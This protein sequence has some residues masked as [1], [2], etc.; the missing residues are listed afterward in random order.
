[1]TNNPFTYLTLF[2]CVMFAIVIIVSYF[3]YHN[4]LWFVIEQLKIA[5]FCIGFYVVLS[6]WAN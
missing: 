2:L 6:I 1:M 5:I 4:P 3:Y